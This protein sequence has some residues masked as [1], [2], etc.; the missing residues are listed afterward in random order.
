M[1]KIFLEGRK[2]G[3]DEALGTGRKRS[4]SGE[5]R[6]ERK[7]GRQRGEGRVFDGMGWDGTG[8]RRIVM[9]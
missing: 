9:D 2:K 3:G 5:S 6:N 7:K 4:R 8:L 1:A